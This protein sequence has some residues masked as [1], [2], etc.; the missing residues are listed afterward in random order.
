MKFATQYSK[1]E[2]AGE[3]NN[4]EKKVETLG[5]VPL[6]QRI[7]SLIRSGERLHQYRK[8]Q[9][10]FQNG[11]EVDENMDVRTREPNYD[12]ADAYQDNRV[13][14]LRLQESIQR[15]KEIDNAAKSNLDDPSIKDTKT[16]TEKTAGVEPEEK[17]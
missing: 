17:T 8:E 15:Q 3:D 12:I 7:E 16:D 13:A 9:F 5:Y 4:Q 11:E 2:Y 14:S 10:D 1:F 6:G